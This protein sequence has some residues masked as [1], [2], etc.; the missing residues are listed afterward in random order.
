MIASKQVHPK[1][2]IPVYSSCIMSQ[3]HNLFLKGKPLSKSSIRA[4]EG[5]RDNV[6][7]VYLSPEIDPFIFMLIIGKTITATIIVDMR[8]NSSRN[9]SKSLLPQQ[10]TS[11]FGRLAFDLILYLA[12]FS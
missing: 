8:N 4:K 9:S 7:T 11:C 1:S 2:P 5:T 6:F 10:V 12:S 3:T